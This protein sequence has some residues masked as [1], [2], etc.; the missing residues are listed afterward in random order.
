MAGKNRQLIANGLLE[1]EGLNRI[2]KK[3]KYFFFFEIDIT[4]MFS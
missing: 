2:I 4:I 3:L 1:V